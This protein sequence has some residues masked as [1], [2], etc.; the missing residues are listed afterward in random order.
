MLLILTALALTLVVFYFGLREL[1]VAVREQRRLETAVLPDE[2]RAGGLRWSTIDRQLLRISSGRRLRETLEMSGVSTA[3]SKF[4]AVAVAASVLLGL[5]LAR[6]LS[7]LLFPL[8]L[9]LGLQLTRV[10]LRR[11]KNKRREAFISQMPEL[12]RTL[13]NA[14]SAG[15]SVRT[16]LAMAVDELADPA[17]SEIR[18]VT[19]QLNLG[20]SL[21]GALTN[22]ER[23]LPS[24]EAAI[25]I[26]TLIVSARSG[27][28]LVTALRDIAGTLETRKETRREIR[29][30]YA[31]AVATAYAVLLMGVGVLFLLD[32][33]HEGTVDTMLREPLGQV[34]LVVAG[35]IYAAGILVI[36]R[37]TRVEV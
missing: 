3:P 35:G 22:M 26:S 8:G 4:L 6:S 31:Q 20:A 12:A 28:G 7:G 16:A 9:L 11:A 10:Y 17:R 13:S 24:R 5:L 30:V 29:T 2:R 18:L 23:R 25:L 32:S 15:L 34:A 37:M 19:E 21:D 36:R 14:T 33:V 27:G 1:G